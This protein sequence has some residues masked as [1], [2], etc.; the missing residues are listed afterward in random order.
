[1]VLRYINLKMG[2]LKSIILMELS[3]FYL[4]MEV[5]DI[6]IMMVT[7]KHFSQMEMFKK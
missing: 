2:K 5:K 4:M 7:K 6:Y 1:M 3:R